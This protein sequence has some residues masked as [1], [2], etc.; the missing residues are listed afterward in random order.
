M[1][2]AKFGR[3][4]CDRNFIESGLKFG[5]GRKIKCAEVTSVDWRYPVGS[6][7]SVKWLVLLSTPS[8]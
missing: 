2:K 3:L 4:P 5:G 1:Y 6:N 7:L 8:Y